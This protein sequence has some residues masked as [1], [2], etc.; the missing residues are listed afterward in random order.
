MRPLTLTLGIALALAGAAQ[1]SGA[2]D[3]LAPHRG[4]ARILVVAAPDAQDP[5]LRAQRELLVPVRAE[6]RER[7]LVVVEA[8]GTGPEAAALRRRLGLPEGAFRAALV[9]KDG[10]AKL[11][12]AEPLTPQ[13][14][15][16]TIDAMP[17][18]QDEVRERR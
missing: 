7:D 9:G 13:R 4:K 11:K 18:R 3:P 1:V 6:L 2:P 14:L 10:G 5:S 17:M 12:A 8:I 15:F 16:A